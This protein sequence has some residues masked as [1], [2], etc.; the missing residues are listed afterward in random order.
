MFLEHGHQ[1]LP[2]PERRSTRKKSNMTNL[3]MDQIWMRSCEKQTCIN[4]NEAHNYE[5]DLNF[6]Q[7]ENENL[8]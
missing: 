1:L 6:Y 8:K 7:K 4:L 3:K 2:E 5:R